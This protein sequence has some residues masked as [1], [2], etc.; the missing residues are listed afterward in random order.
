VQAF[1]G[2]LAC[3]TII[4]TASQS[5]RPL[6]FQATGRSALSSRTF[7]LPDGRDNPAVGPVIDEG[8]G[9]GLWRGRIWTISV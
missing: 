8:A 5:R 4:E 1:V 6:K 9:G 2:G 3:A 7:L